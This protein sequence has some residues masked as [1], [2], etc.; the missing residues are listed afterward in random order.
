MDSGMLPQ[1]IDQ[2]S[3]VFAVVYGDRDQLHAA[4][5]KGLVKRRH[6]PLSG[7]HPGTPRVTSSRVSDEIWISERH[8]KI[9]PE[10]GL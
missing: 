9:G 5:S 3:C 2:H 6:Q 8:A 10:S 1:F 4:L 7:L